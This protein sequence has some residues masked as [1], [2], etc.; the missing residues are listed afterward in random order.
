MNP[1][2]LRPDSRKLDNAETAAVAAPAESNSRTFRLPWQTWASLAL[3]AAAIAFAFRASIADMVHTWSTRPEYSHGP[4]IPLVAAFLV[5][6]QR[7]R[8]ARLEFSGSW[9]SIALIG[10]GILLHLVGQLATIYVLALYGMLLAMLGVVLAL[11]GATG[12]R[13]LW[14]PL[15]MLAL[16]IPLPHFLLNNLSAELQLLS[17]R[18]G[19]WVIRL[20]GVSVHLSGNVIDLG[21]YKLQVAEACDGLRYLFPLLTLGFVMAC[22]FKAPLWKRAI[23]LFSSIPI[24]VLMN[25]FRIGVIGVTVKHWGVRMAEGFLHEFQGWLVFML[26]AALMLG[27]MILLNKVG[28]D[29]KPW[30]EAFRIDLPAR[31]AKRAAA[32]PRAVPRPLTAVTLIL[33]GYACVAALLPER[34]QTIPLRPSLADFPSRLGDWYG[35]HDSLEPIYLRSLRLSD[36]LLANY[37]RAETPPVNLYVAWYDSQLAGQSA[38]SPRSCMPGGGWQMEQV[39]RTNLVL[40]PDANQSVRV[41]RAVI[42]RGNDRQVVYYWFQQRGRVITNEYLVKWYLLVDALRQNRTDGALVRL[43]TAVPQGES[44]AQADARLT[45]FA[46][47]AAPRLQAYIPGKTLTLG[48]RPSGATP[49]VL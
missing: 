49:P 34:A 33:V 31:D 27:L 3:A 18:I 21:I 45:E 40:G 35:E 24:T 9:W 16:M 38:H 12:F 15:V 20:F 47:E 14:A 17:S 5:W 41:N 7:D 25:S 43:V 11:A 26:S 4:L 8:I 44:I 37:G 36:Y 23:V 28:S 19:V 30:H 6:Q 1:S 32:T 46:R 39:E 42:K 22:F 29:R 10:A 2:R 48:A 13:A